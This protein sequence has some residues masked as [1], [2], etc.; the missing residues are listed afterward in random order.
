MMGPAFGSISTR[1]FGLKSIF[2]IAFIDTLIGFSVVIIFVLPK[3]RQ[4]IRDEEPAKPFHFREI[5]EILSN[6]TV[7]L[8]CFAYF[9]IFFLYGANLAFTPIYAKD[10]FQLSEDVVA[11]LFTGYFLLAVAV[12]LILGRLIDVFG[13]YRL[14]LFG[15]INGFVMGLVMFLAKANLIV[16]LIAFFLTGI[17]HGMVFPVGTILIANAVKRSQLFLAN[18]LY[19]FGFDLGGGIGPIFTAYLVLY[20][21]IPPTYFLS[22]LFPLAAAILIYKYRTE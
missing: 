15:L 2:Y 20:L 9:A 7:A 8:S 21:G 17:S 4:L 18:S 3:I 16:F 22:G 13:T 6:K 1:L 11:G 19:F 14:M 12:R 5:P 10:Y